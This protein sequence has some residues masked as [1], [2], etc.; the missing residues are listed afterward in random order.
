M[1]IGV[2]YH[3]SREIKLRM[4]SLS[5]FCDILKVCFSVGDLFKSGDSL[6]GLWSYGA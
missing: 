4:Y 1:C 6:E 5:D 3:V 2:S